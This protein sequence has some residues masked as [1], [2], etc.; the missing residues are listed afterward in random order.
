[1]AS[2]RKS[3]KLKGRKSTAQATHEE[4]RLRGLLHITPSDE[5]CFALERDEPSRTF[6]SFHNKSRKTQVGFEIK[7]KQAASS[8]FIIEPLTGVVFPGGV[9]R[10]M[11]TMTGSTATQ[12]LAID[13]GGSEIRN[14]FQIEIWR[15]TDKER[16][17]KA[18]GDLGFGFGS[19]GV[20]GAAPGAR[21]A[22]QTIVASYVELFPHMCC[23]FNAIMT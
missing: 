8:L 17:G 22:G 14:A 12:L 15:V 16:G 23:F 7:T 10:V 6:L 9:H 13:G 1:M 4:L 2:R 21:V 20:A 3:K 11:I 5:L 18:K 19:S